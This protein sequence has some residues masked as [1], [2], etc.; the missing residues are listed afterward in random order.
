MGVAY[1]GMYKISYC[2]LL[3]LRHGYMHVYYNYYMLHSPY[4]P[5]IKA[6]SSIMGLLWLAMS[7]VL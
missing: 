6:I 1:I 3:F 4:K 2:M 5:K 7:V